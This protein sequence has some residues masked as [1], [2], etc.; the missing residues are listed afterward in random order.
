M[1]FVGN[2]NK[3]LGSLILTFF[4]IVSLVGTSY[5]PIVMQE[6]EHHRCLY[7]STA[8]VCTMTPLQH[9]SELQS[10]FMVTVQPFS[11]LGLIVLAL[12]VIYTFIL[13]RPKEPPETRS[14]LVV[15]PTMRAASHLQIAFS[16]G[17]LNPKVF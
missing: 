6:G 15:R 13:I 17:I 12:A 5:F 3:I 8:A 16:R 2:R 4:V 11:A 9:L 10:H 7:M 14:V 1:I